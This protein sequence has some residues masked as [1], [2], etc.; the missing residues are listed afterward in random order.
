[1]ALD[2]LT[3]HDKDQYYPRKRKDINNWI[4]NLQHNSCILKLKI[5]QKAFQVNNLIICPLANKKR[6]WFWSD[7]PSKKKIIVLSMDFLSQL[8]HH[9]WGR[10]QW[11]TRKLK[12]FKCTNNSLTIVGWSHIYNSCNYAIMPLL[13]VQTK[14]LFKFALLSK[15]F[16]VSG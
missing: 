13:E 5:V 7:T 3:V 2:Q 16:Y 9:M 14:L 6:T 12:S 15:Y 8:V 4:L 10:L 11:K 1:M